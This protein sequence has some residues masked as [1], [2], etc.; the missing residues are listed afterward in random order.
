MAETIWL[1]RHRRNSNP[2]NVRR[3]TENFITIGFFSSAQEARD[4]VDGHREAEGFIDYPDGWD[5]QELLLNVLLD[6]PVVL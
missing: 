6:P 1:V 5:I 4:A 3:N 2:P